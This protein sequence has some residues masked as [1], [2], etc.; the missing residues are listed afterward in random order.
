MLRSRS[1]YKRR[2][3]NTAKKELL[4]VKQTIHALG[5]IKLPF[6]TGAVSVFALNAN[7]I[8]GKQTKK[9]KANTYVLLLLLHLH[10]GHVKLLID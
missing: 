7:T 10:F 9:F 3:Q 6:C 4:K 5:V 2:L 8:N 1:F